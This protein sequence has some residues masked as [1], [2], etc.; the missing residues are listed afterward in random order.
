MAFINLDAIMSHVAKYAK[1]KAGRQKIGDV[2]DDYIDRGV[3]RTNAGSHIVSD[4]D[5][6]AVAEE[7]MLN[8][9][10]AASQSAALGTLPDSVAEHF[11]SL[12]ITAQQRMR[13]KKTRENVV[14]FEISFMDD[15]SRQS[16]L[17][18]RPPKGGRQY[19]ISSAYNGRTGEGVENI[20]ASF[21]YGYYAKGTVYGYWESA[22]LNVWSVS[23]RTGLHLIRDVIDDFNAKYGD[24]AKATLLWDNNL[25]L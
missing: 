23:A 9:Q 24:R 16:L 3:E 5:C 6:F 15:L 12:R 11:E 22:G 2:I 7:L 20:V 10:N 17:A 21:E 18:V 25:G 14:R 8:L 19:S 1:T 13:N 4:D